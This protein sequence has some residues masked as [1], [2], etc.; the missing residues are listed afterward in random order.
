M[1]NETLLSKV[2]ARV[3]SM[4]GCSADA[5]TGE[6][7]HVLGDRVPRLDL[8]LLGIGDDGH[9]CSLFPGRPELVVTDRWVV[10]VDRPGMP[11]M[12]PRLTL[13]FPALDAAQVALFLVEGE[14][15]R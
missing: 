4:V 15:K 3:H 9:T 6:L 2:D 1:A 12:H 10:Y 7:G 5:Y 8:L 11:P 13:T 14:R